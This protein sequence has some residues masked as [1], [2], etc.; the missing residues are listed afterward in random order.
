MLFFASPG[1]ADSPNEVR[2][3]LKVNIEAVVVLLQDE[4]LDKSHRNE[5]IIEII[6]PVFDY[7]AMAKLS[8][9]KKYWPKLSKEKQVAFSDLFIKRLQDSYLEKLDLYSDEEVL[10]GEPQTKGKQVHQPTTLIYRDSRISMLYKFYRSATGWKVYDVEIGGVSVIQTY[11]SQFD[12]VL[13]EGNIDDLLER[14][15]NGESFTAP[16]P[17]EKAARAGTS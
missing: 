1:L 13:S 17:N 7:Q 10:Y 8:L 14:L 6:T 3:L 11:R 5:Q 2:E 9:G 15:R 12:G 16:E 4:S